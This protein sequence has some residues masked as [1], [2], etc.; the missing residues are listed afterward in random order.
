MVDSILKNISEIRDKIML[1]AKRSSRD[2]S[3]IRLMGVSKTYPVEYMLSAAAKLDIIG[4]NKIQEAVDKRLNWPS[5]EKIPWHLIGHLQRNKARKALEVFDL[6][7]TV[8]SLDL[9]RMLDRILAETDGGYFPVYLEINMS[10]ELTKNG[11]PPQEAA[12]LLERIMQYC[13]CLSVEG[14]MTIGPNIDEEIE[15]RKSFEGL[16]ILRD[17]LSSVSGLP[18]RELS[19]GMSNDYEIAVEEGST[20]VRVGT[21]IFGLRTGPIFS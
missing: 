8:D 14:L 15:I 6:I 3:D 21:G 10:G 1:A 13:P 7:E 19:M 12:S 9:A 2:P 16:R 20:I 18:L 17:Q 5:G 11:A 4:E